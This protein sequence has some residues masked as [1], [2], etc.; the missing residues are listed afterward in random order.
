LTTSLVSCPACEHEW[1]EEVELQGP[2]PDVGINGG[3]MLG[4]LQCP[5]C[6]H[7]FTDA[8]REAEES[9]IYEAKTSDDPWD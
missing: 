3:A 7:V 6:E 4:D 2:E 9:K 1:R 8:E 5:E